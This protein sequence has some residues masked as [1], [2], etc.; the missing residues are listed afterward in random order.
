MTSKLYTYYPEFD[1]DDC[2][3]WNVYENTTQ[4]IIETF[5]FEDDAVE[6]MEN[7]ENGKGFQGFTPSFI[8]RKVRNI[9]NINDAFSAEFAE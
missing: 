2:L 9:S 8:V 1:A 4:Q 7:L 5:L 6:F 3:F